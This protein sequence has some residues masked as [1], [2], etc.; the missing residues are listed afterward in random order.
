MCLADLELWQFSRF[1]YKQSSY[2]KSGPDVKGLHGN[3]SFELFK[4]KSI[5]KLKIL[6]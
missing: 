5:K 1:V 2:Y 4:K 6:Q 3:P